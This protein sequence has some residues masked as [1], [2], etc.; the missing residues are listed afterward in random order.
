MN[1]KMAHS[2]YL[3]GIDV[4][5]QSVRAAVID[6]NGHTLAFGVSQLLTNFPQPGW[7][8]Q[9]PSEWWT[10]IQ[11][12]VSKALEL[13]QI[14]GAA[15]RGIG[16]DSTACT[17]VACQ[18]DGKA[19]IPALLW[20]DQRSASE[21]AEIDAT[22]DDSLKYVSGRV[23]PEWMLP[24][25]LWIKRHAPE[26][27]AQADR[28]VECT[29]WL[30]HQLT[31]EWSLSLNHCAVKWNYARA[32]GGW[33]LK[34][35]EKVGIADL[36]GKWPTDMIPLGGGAC[37]LSASAANWLG[38]QAG[39]PVAQGGIDAYLGMI[40]LGATMEGDVALII[41]S[42]T[43]H[44]AQS[45][46]PLF[47]SGW[48]GSYPDATV[49]GLYTLEAGQTATG[50][51]L[52][53]YRRH[54]AGS[55]QNQADLLGISIFSLL[56]QKAATAPP[57]SDGILIRD[58][59][60]GNRSPFKNPSARGAITG[61]TLAHGPGHIIRAIYESTALGTRQILED[62]VSH[63]LNL[64][65][66]VAGGGG[67]KSQLWMQIQADVLQRPI[68]LTRDPESCALGSTMAAAIAA[69]L[70]LNFEEAAAQMVKLERVVE[71]DPGRSAAYNE[72]YDRYIELYQRLNSS[73]NRNG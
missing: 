15:I 50:S 70:F 56:D 67:V 68:T 1:L 72:L 27:Y 17:V 39:T 71:P 73:T 30:M 34:L 37:R 59:W 69:G 63:G 8:E 49:E 46:I 57:G 65:R 38:L 18:S 35:M 11:E 61:L 23:S 5:T 13:A 3:L 62:G 6:L 58:D 36:E 20:M 2:E 45:K 12:A 29:N 31:G 4:G 26:V 64:K 55:E 42:S 19:I 53:W 41:G 60:Q 28:I 48:A 33:P 40:G 43:C 66:I 21:A 44:L 47:G 54:F 14:S 24:K 32:E 16:L 25:A 9:N 22:F 10:A 52:D 51:I 7:A